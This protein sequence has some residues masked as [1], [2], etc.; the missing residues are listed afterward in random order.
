MGIF[1]KKVLQ[2]KNGLSLISFFV[3]IMLLMLLL[4]LISFYYYVRGSQGHAAAVSC[5]HSG[6][7]NLK[8]E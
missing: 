3:I 8:V 7:L 6:E 5:K 2:D 4:K 1:A